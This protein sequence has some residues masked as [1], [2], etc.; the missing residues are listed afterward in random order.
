VRVVGQ[1]C[2]SASDGADRGWVAGAI[3]AVTL[4][5]LSTPW[6]DRSII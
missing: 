3:W 2:A 6:L 5:I 4:I 1:V